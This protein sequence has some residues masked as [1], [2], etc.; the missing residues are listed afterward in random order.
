MGGLTGYGFATLERTYYARRQALVVLP[1]VLR[2]AREAVLEEEY[3]QR[4]GELD[5]HREVLPDLRCLLL[6]KALIT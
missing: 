1:E 2:A 5:A 4:L 6:I 3:R